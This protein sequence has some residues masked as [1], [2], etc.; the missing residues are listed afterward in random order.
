MIL[1]YAFDAVISDNRYGLY[2]R[3]V[4]CIFIT[5]QLAIKT[6][7]GK[8]SEKI[9]QKRNYRFINRFTTCWVPDIEGDNNLAGEL[10]H[11]IKKPK[12]PV[13]YIGLLSRFDSSPPP[14]GGDGG[15]DHILIIL[16]GP[17]PQR[18]ILEDKIIQEIGHYY[19][20]ATIVRGLPGSLSV[21]PS[22]N[23]IK[24]YN[25][26]PADALNKEMLQAE[27]VIGRCGYSTVMDLVKLQKKNILVPTP[28]Q[29]EQEY[30]SK[31]LFEKQIALC[32]PQKEFSLEDALSRAKQFTYH[33]PGMNNGELLQKPIADLISSL[34]KK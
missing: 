23:M 26:L 25:H 8:W 33:F 13:K 3:S 9:L 29:T 21:I 19:G 34:T 24:F 5:H 18:S 32:I 28:G 2:H 16:S 1:E 17:E 11:P 7:L 15:K 4:P 27:Y 30:L 6:P 10:S 20:T 31:Y 12:I 22:S 14:A